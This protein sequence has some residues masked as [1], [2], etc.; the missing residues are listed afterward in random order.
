MDTGDEPSRGQEPGLDDLDLPWGEYVDE[1]YD[2]IDLDEESD[3]PEAT[4]RYLDLVRQVHEEADEAER[5]GDRSVGLS[6]GALAIIRQSVRAEGRRGAQVAMPPTEEG[7]FSV[8][9]AALRSIVRRAVD[10]VGGVTSV[11]TEHASGTGPSGGRAGLARSG[12]ELPQPERITCRV[13]VSMSAGSLPV[14]AEQVRRAV[15]RALE[16]E[17][18]LDVPV[19]DVHIED[20][21]E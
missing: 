15:A 8:S 13:Q 10:G 19:V 2:D 18:G 12:G 14:L 21:H 17:L 7:P 5:A 3:D 11:R 20:V 1:P 4:R 16:E 6:A 9:E